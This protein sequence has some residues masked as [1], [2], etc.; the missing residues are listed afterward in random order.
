MNI[1]WEDLKPHN[2]S[3]I[4]FSKRQ[5][6][7]E[8]RIRLRVTLRTCLAIV[9]IEVDFLVANVSNNTYN[10]ILGKTLLNKARVIVSTSHLLM[11]FPT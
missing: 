7:V 4:G 1:H 3:L 5:V 11:K 10:P 6:P 9:N 2:E 8:G